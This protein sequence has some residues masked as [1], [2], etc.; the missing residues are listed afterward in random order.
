MREFAELLST[1]LGSEMQL[2]RDYCAQF[3]LGAQEL[4][5]ARARPACQAYS[6]FCISTAATG[7]PLE[8]LCALIPCGL[9]YAE[10]GARL[11]A[12]AQSQPGGLAA[13]PYRGWIETYGGAEY[14]H[15]AQWMRTTLDQL[16]A[17]AP[18]ASLP[19]LQQLFDLGCR[20]EWLFWEMS[21]TGE[22]WEI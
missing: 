12:A 10:I 14:Q 8:L 4:E 6:D 21:W 20:Y 22:D 5:A 16:A 9:G 18:A 11:L 7:G 19:H 15:Y 1:T 3:G 17:E 13:Q 2:H